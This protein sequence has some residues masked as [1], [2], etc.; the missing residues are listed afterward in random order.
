MRSRRVASRS[1]VKWSNETCAYSA[2]INVGSATE[3]KRFS[4]VPTAAIYGMRKA[5]NFDIYIMHGAADATDPPILWA[6]LYIPEGVSTAGITLNAGDGT[7][8]TSLYEPNQHIIVSG[9]ADQTGITRA[10]S[11]L[12]RNLNSGDQVILV[13]TYPPALQ[14]RNNTQLN[15]RV[16]YSISL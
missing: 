14:A 8:Y 11:P 16:N 15:L 1:N 7:V 13:L 6:L 12:A 2:V 9:I 4:V 3:T 10:F 5:K